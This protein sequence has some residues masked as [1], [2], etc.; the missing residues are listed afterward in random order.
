MRSAGQAF[1][2]QQVCQ[3]KYI[4]HFQ[5]QG[6]IFQ[7][8][9]ASSTGKNPSQEWLRF[10]VSPFQ[11]DTWL[12]CKHRR[13]AFDLKATKRCLL[14]LLLETSCLRGNCAPPDVDHNLGCFT[15]GEPPTKEGQNCIESQLHCAG[16]FSLCLFHSKPVFSR[17]AH[18]QAGAAPTQEVK[19]D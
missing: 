1:Y 15:K 19:R 4:K 13:R 16:E 14:M 11:V 18:N 10:P 3:L 17:P 12:H 5:Q 9:L 7:D 8:I 2:I 6:D